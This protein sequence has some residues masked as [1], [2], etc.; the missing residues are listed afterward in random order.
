MHGA[1][2]VCFVVVSEMAIFR[3]YPQPIGQANFLETNQWLAVLN[4]CTKIQRRSGK[5][6]IVQ[7]VRGAR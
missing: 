7:L 3:Q 5:Q 6:S 4:S 1:G 2:E